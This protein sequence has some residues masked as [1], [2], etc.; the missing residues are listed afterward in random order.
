MDRI[1]LVILSKILN[2]LKIK[3]IKLNFDYHEIIDSEGMLLFMKINRFD[4]LKINNEIFNLPPFYNFVNQKDVSVYL[5][6]FLKK[7]II[8]KDTF[9]N[10]LNR[11]LFLVDVGLWKSKLNKFQSLHIN[12]KAWWRDI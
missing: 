9:G 5:K 6:T 3:V 1:R 11:A 7:R 8:E 10:E 12:E 4:L 2:K